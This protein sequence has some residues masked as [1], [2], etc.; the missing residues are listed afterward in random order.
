MVSCSRYWKINRW[1][2]AAFDKL[3]SKAC[4][5]K[6]GLMVPQAIQF[7]AKQEPEELKKQL[8]QIGNRF[9]VKP[10]RQGS[11]IGVG[12]ADD[13]ASAI[14][15]A[16]QCRS[17]FGDCMIEEYIE[18]REITVG[19][20][21]GQALPIIEIRSRSGFYDYEAKY[22]DDET[23]FLFNTIENREL[24]GAIEKTAVASFD[25]LGCRHFARADFII[26]SEQNVYIL[27]VNTIP[28]FTNH[29]LLP[30][31]AVRAGISMS[32]LCLKIVEA[33]LT[34]NMVEAFVKA[35]LNRQ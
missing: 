28:G 26:D 4:F 13:A 25:V 1:F 8:Q 32:D 29:S 34:N 17:E 20:L 5:A 21:G 9:V 14:S 2:K 7:D 11:T 24:V 31:A 18:G 30:M 23:E 15:A 19:V 12:I 35:S 27:E 10:L 3:A 16:G 6:S 33:A 22:L